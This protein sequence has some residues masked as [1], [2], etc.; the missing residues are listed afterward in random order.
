MT[1]QTR[2]GRLVAALALA[3]ALA[4]ALAAPSG[5]A[6]FPETVPLPDR[7]SPEGIAAGPGT[8]FFAGSRADGSVYRAD[9]RTGQGAVLVPGEAGGIAVGMQ[10]D[11]SS[12]LLWVAGG[13][14]G[15]ITAYDGRTGR[16]VARYTAPTTS[17]GRFLNDVDVT[18][19]GVFV[20]DS[21]NAELLVVRS[22]AL[23]RLPLRGDWVQQASGNS[24]N[25]IRVLPGGDLLV[26]SPTGLYRVS[27]TTGVADR[28]EQTGGRAL[29]GGDGLVLR[30]STLYVVVGYG[31]TS[32]SVT[33]ASLD[34]AGRSFATTGELRD[35]DLERPTTAAL[36]AGALYAVN[37]KFNTAGATTFEVV[38]V[39]V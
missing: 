13:T 2:T 23:S 19:D 15:R 36:I 6:S 35:S 12:G 31:G 9:A 18:K 39:A 32:D 4:L 34:R 25:G 38:R 29:A 26:V 30:G 24:A 11:P 3:P 33:V 7:S 10:Y 27:P 21:L 14:T 28:L 20:T 22:G 1:L 37:G 8:T 17:K 16:R 5:A